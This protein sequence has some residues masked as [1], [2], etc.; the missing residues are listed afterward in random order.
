MRPPPR[1]NSIKT[2]NNVTKYEF[3]SHNSFMNQA[4]RASE[5]PSKASIPSPPPQLRS[6]QKNPSPLTFCSLNKFSQNKHFI[7]FLFTLSQNGPTHFQT[8][9]FPL[10]SLCSHLILLLKII[11]LMAPL[12]N[13]ISLLPITLNLLKKEI[14]VHCF[15]YF[16]SH[17]LANFLQMEFCTH[18]FSDII[19]FKIFFQSTSLNKPESNRTHLTP[20][21]S[22]LNLGFL[23]APNLGLPYA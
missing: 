22:W 10:H 15:N 8:S 4:K 20:V 5:N 3:S 11:N 16:N 13:I 23:N 12:V 2:F 17:S 14:F 1:E 18:N 9:A 7:N 6:Y 21:Y 19:I